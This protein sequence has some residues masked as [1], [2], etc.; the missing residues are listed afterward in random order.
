MNEWVDIAQI[1]TAVITLI[2]VLTSIWLSVKALREVEK[3]RKLN[4]KPF[5]VFETGAV[6]LRVEFLK[7]G[8]AIPGINP[9][10][11]KKLFSHLPE[12]IESIRLKK[13]N[14]KIVKYGHLK[15]YGNG[16]ALEV[17]VTFIP[18]RIWI[19]SEEFEISQKQRNEPQ[20]KE[21]LNRLPISP[22][23]V[24]PDTEGR[25]SRIPTFIEKD[26]EKKI[27]RIEGFVKISYTDVFMNEH[28]TEQ[29]FR[30][31]GKYKEEEKF[32][33]ILFL[34]IKDATNNKS[35]K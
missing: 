12:D 7:K 10:Y 2:G 18:E 22:S 17:N 9:A 5:L 32:I 14:D 16:P 19:G 6:R 28:F 31:F 13:N 26:F 29:G 34:D 23:H 35:T 4:H 20:Y 1:T 25:L 24:M 27:S 21:E 30:I 3:D 33:Q 11:V 15:N 8:K